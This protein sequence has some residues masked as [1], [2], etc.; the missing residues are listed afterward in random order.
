MALTPGTKL[1]PYE[2]QS[3]LGAGGMGEVYRARDMRLD[4][5]VAIKILPLHLSEKPEAKERFD[6]EARALSSLSHPNICHLYDVGQQDGISYLVMEY[7]EGETLAD[8]LRKGSLPLEQV[9]RVAAEICEGLEKAHRS[10]VVHRD[11]KPGNIMLTKSGAKLMD[12]GLAKA[13]C[14]AVGAGSSSDSLAT[15]SGPLTTEGTIVGTIQYMSPEQVEGKEADA[16]SDIFSLG[17]VLYEMITGKRAF[18][19]KTAASTIAAILAVEPKPLSTV[20]PLSPPSFERVVKACLAKDPDE[21]LQTAHDLKLQLKWIA[22]VAPPTAPPKVRPT[23]ERW[24]WM[25]LVAILIAGLILLY[26]RASPNVSQPTLSYIPAPEKTSLAYFTGPVTLSHD[27]RTLAFVA[28]TFEGRDLVW[29]RPL[30]APEARAL[31]GTEGASSPFW[32]TDDRSI[33]FF[34]GGKLKT[35]EPAG[36]PVVTICDAPGPRGG[37][38]NQNG[39]ILF[40]T[41]WSGIYRVPSSGGTPTEITKVDTSHGEST[42]RWPYFLPDGQHFLY[43]AGV[44]T[45]AASIRLGTLDSSD[46]KILFPARSNAAYTSGYVLYVRDRMLMAQAFDE[47]KLEVRGQ[48]F[49]VTQVLYDQLLWRGVFSCSANGILAYQGANNGA[50]SRLI[51]FDRAGQEIKTVGAPGDFNSHRISPDGQRLAVTVLD[52]SVANYKLWVYDLVRGKETRLTFGTNRENSPIWT[53]DG[54]SLTFAS[55][56]KGAYDIFEK[57]SDTTGSEESVLESVAAKTPT[58]WSP[59]ARFLAYTS[60]TPGNSKASVWILPRFGDRK[61]Y[62]F[63]Q[64]D[65]NIG[66]GSFSPDGHFLAYSSDESGRLEIYVTPFP[67]GGSKWQVSSAGGANPRWLRD[68]KELFY[69]A[70]DS[71]LIAAEVDTRGSVFQVGARRPLFHLALRTGATR[72]DLSGVVGYDAAPDGK[73]FVVNSPPAGNLPPI[74][75]ITNWTPKPGK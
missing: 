38:W 18:E 73:W 70:A 42:H 32:S 26:S 46:T 15:M 40:A 36:A 68:G 57:R 31:A 6:R 65:F 25:S 11:L 56:K 9:L 14:P 63:L 74:T 60:T 71:T 1:G 5:T 34:A 47:K 27:G 39:V 62:I 28:T 8:R 19:G 3:S 69:M 24:I 29:V 75:L 10:G 22:E 52:S 51:M 54:K 35:I 7:L 55:M 72:L 45:A 12:F 44:G 49:P 53:P 66:D 50:D 61:P 67:G 20:Q 30:D 17:A 58:G 2:I 13:A 41:T 21:R 64:G 33:G 4:R 59:D 37:T 16:R 23:R 43:F 48:A